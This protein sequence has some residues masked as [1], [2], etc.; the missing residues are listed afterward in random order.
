MNSKLRSGS[1]RYMNQ[2]K[3][4]AE[5][6]SSDK[7]TPNSTFV[8]TL[9]TLKL[10]AGR[11]VPMAYPHRLYHRRHIPL[12]RRRR[13]HRCHV[14][15]A[16]YLGMCEA[17][18]FPCPSNDKPQKFSNVDFSTSHFSDDVDVQWPMIYI[19]LFGKNGVAWC[20]TGAT[21][22][23]AGL[24]ISMTKDTHIHPPQ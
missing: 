21:C 12:Q 19:Q 6:R 8:E 20:Y 23:I 18:A 11:R 24:H 5:P 16:K 4:T 3:L 13:R 7:N 15:V 1:T 14:M 9:D 2:Q 17:I 10:T 22:S